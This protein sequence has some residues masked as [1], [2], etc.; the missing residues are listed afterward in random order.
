VVLSGSEYESDFANDLGPPK[1][2]KRL[3]NGPNCY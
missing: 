2:K 1:I 3:K